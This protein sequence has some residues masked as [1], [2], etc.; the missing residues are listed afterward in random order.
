MHAKT[1]ARASA[2]KQARNQMHTVAAR[3]RAA[4]KQPHSPL[5]PADPPCEMAKNRR[6]ICPHARANMRFSR[7]SM[8]ARL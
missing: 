4:R 3:E 2:G 1:L 8:T 6:H 5:F 7:E